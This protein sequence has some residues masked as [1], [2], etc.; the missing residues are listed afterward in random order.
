MKNT[1]SKIEKP[2]KLRRSRRS[3]VD[4]TATTTADTTSKSGRRGDTR[5]H[6]IDAA[7]Q[8][9]EADNHGM[10]G[11]SLREVTKAA[12][13]SP[14][15][16]YRH[17]PDLEELGL[18]VLEESADMLR[19]MLRDVRKADNPAEMISKSAETFVRYVLENRAI[20]LLLSRERVGGSA[21]IRAA[22]RNQI[23]HF[24]TELASDLRLMKVLPQMTQTDLQRVAN[25]VISLA[26]NRVPDILDL[27]TEQPREI[28]EAIAD[29]DSQ[30]QILILGAINW[31]PEP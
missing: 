15:A 31:K 5:Q 26:I 6:L 23:S 18:A 24:I 4:K 21:R 9:I 3:K 27:P 12:G 8:R 22:I 1:D 29:M 11:I 16:F 17:F 30:L 28:E 25:M 20:W 14:T 10:A 2:P 7:L 13:V 19:R